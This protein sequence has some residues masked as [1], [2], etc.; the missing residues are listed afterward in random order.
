MLTEN[1]LDSHK[2]LHKFGNTAYKIGYDR[3]PRPTAF[4]LPSDSLNVRFHVGTIKAGD[5]VLQKEQKNFF[6]SFVCFYMTICRL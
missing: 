6:A 2:S 3:F 1:I 5:S 4:P